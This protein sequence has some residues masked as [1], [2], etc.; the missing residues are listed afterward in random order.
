M[1]SKGFREYLCPN[2]H[3]FSQDDDIFYVDEN[4]GR[5]K[6]CH[7]P[8]KFLCVVNRANGFS[9]NDVSTHYGFLEVVGY[10][11][12]VTKDH[13]NNVYYERIIKYTHVNGPGK[14]LWREIIQRSD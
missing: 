3:V 1:E 6:H 11:E 7:K 12:R 9:E 4:Q 2:G 14:N 8:F 10:D 5:C 13:R